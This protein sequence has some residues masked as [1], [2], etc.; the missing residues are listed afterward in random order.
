MRGAVA[1]TDILRIDPERW[2]LLG[3][4]ADLGLPDA[5]I[6]AGFVRNAIWDALHG[7]APQRI[8]GDI[9]VI[10]FDADCTSVERDREIEA[11]LLASARHADWSVKNQARMHVRNGDAPYSCSTD[12]MRYWPETATAVAARRM[13]DGTCLIAAPF[14]LDD[15][16]GGRI[17]PTPHFA[18]IR[19]ATFL[20]RV[21]G[22]QWL[23]KWP[24]LTL[25]QA[26]ENPDL[27]G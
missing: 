25:M 26:A 5:W 7:R 10:W 2:A 11:K 3:L 19:R 22:K 12:A 8:T 13:P 21:H 23:E 17:R 14:G 24:C 15:L 16:L 6:A 4:V 9:D 18:G 1:V 27:S 20:G